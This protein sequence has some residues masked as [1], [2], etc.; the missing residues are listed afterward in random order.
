MTIASWRTFTRDDVSGLQLEGK[1]NRW[2][3]VYES[4]DG[5]RP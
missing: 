1:W 5:R 3:S 4:C 2:R